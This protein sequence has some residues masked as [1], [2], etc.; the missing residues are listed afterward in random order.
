MTEKQGGKNNGAIGTV[1]TSYTGFIAGQAGAIASVKDA[2]VTDATVDGMQ[3]FLE[4]VHRVKNKEAHLRTGH[5]FET[6][7]AYKEN[8]DAASKSAKLK[9]Y[10]THLEKNNKDAADLE[11]KV[12]QNIVSKVQ[13]KFTVTND[14]TSPEFVKL[15]KDISDQKYSGMDLYVPADRIELVRKE[16][17]DRAAKMTDPV[18]KARYLDAAKRLVKHDTK[19]REVLVA[20]KAPRLYAAKQEAIA[21]GKEVAFSAGT[22]AASAAIVGGAISAVKNVYLTS[23]GNITA[24][25]AAMA[26]AKDTGKSAGRGAVTGGL[27][28][29][30]RYT[31]VKM[32]SKVLSKSNVATA[33]AAGAIDTGAA[34]LAYARGEIDGAVAVERIGQNGVST[35]SSIYAGAAAGA[36]FGPVGAIVGSMAGYL[37]ASSLYSSTLAL[38]RS[39]SLAIAEAER[40]EYL[41]AAAAHEINTQSA[42]VERYVDA[43]LIDQKEEFFALLR[44][45]KASKDSGDCESVILAISDLAYSLGIRLK[46]ENFGEFDDFMVN[47]MGPLRL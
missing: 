14:P 3:H 26:V 1:S 43:F 22:A 17:E 45:L 24:S 11:R 29:G 4:M 18:E 42:E 8:T 39:G 28:A 35:M 19:V 33:V 31:A 10:I 23:K 13:T 9:T 38:L 46:F 32:S 37:V 41:C 6:I 47:G 34:V 12:G 2:T 25:E 16:L 15:V 44:R 5:L 40:V 36:V 20:T 30:I 27:G 21:V 7:I